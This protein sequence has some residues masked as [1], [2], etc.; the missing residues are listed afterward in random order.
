M[1]NLNDDDLHN[2]IQETQN[3]TQ[4]PVIYQLSRNKEI[5]MWENTL[6]IH[7]NVYDS[8]IMKMHEIDLE[9]KRLNPDC[10]LQILKLIVSHTIM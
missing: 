1:L 10:K 4:E 9:I 5:H 2:L 6:P 8:A 7:R 3:N